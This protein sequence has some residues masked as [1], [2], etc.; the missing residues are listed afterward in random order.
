LGHHTTGGFDKPGKGKEKPQKGKLRKY[1]YFQAMRAKLEKLD[2]QRDAFTGM[3]KKYG[4]KSG[5]RGP[6]TETI[7]L[8]NIR[9]KK[10][11]FICDHLWFNLT[12]GFEKLGNLKEGDTIQFEARVGKYKKGYI[13]RKAGIDQTAVDYK[14]SHPTKVMKVVARK[15]NE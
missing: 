1:I 11:N 3:F 12:K 8:V 5:Y 9:D 15:T 10:G 2:T 4:T 6:A 13:N 7:L 14:L